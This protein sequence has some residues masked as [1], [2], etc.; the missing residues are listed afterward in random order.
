[1]KNEQIAEL[2]YQALETETGGIQVYETALTCVINADLKK[3][4][5]E[6][7]SIRTWSRRGGWSFATSASRWS[8]PWRRRST[9]GRRRPR[10]WWRASAWSRPRRGVKTAIGAARAKKAR[11]QML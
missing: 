7:D 11:K 2:L 10:S 4:W 1:M 5:E 6:Y 9:P 3:E 8:R